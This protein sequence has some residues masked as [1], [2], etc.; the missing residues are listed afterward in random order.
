[1]LVNGRSFEQR[2]Y[3]G[4]CK[5]HEAEGFDPGSGEV[6]Q[7]L[8]FPSLEFKM[9]DNGRS[10]DQSAYAECKFHEAEGFDLESGEVTQELENPFFR[11]AGED[12]VESD[13]DSVD[14]SAENS[15]GNSVLEIPRPLRDA[16]F[17]FEHD[18]ESPLRNR[19][20]GS[21]LPFDWFVPEFL[22]KQW[23]KPR[24][25]STQLAELTQSPTQPQLRGWGISVVDLT[26]EY[27]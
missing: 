24:L 7:E 11:V 20:F 2:V 27:Q 16:N 14:D 21:S 10:F 3:A 8:G 19:R 23:K 6:P 12:D 5:F 25:P 15:G 26:A 22:V 18:T 9:L 13:D 1:M 4:V 17:F